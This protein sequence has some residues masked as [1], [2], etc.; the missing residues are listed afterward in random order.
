MKRF[1]TLER[2]LDYEFVLAAVNG[3]LGP[4]S[5]DSDVC[6]GCGAVRTQHRLRSEESAGELPTTIHSC[7]CGK[8]YTHTGDGSLFE[9]ATVP[10]SAAR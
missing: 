10:V 1:S 2:L 7:Q 6:P 5:D 4:S 9:L 8:L 3:F